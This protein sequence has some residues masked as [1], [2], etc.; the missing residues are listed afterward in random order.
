MSMNLRPADDGLRSLQATGPVTGRFGP[1]PIDIAVLIEELA[2]KLIKISREGGHKMPVAVTAA[3][4]WTEGK[5]SFARLVIDV[6]PGYPD[7]T[8]RRWYQWQHVRF[9]QVPATPRATPDAVDIAWVGGTSHEA[10]P[11]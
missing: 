9:V 2:L 7:G 1:R 10:P 6:A 3:Q 11:R 8:L 5:H 4:W